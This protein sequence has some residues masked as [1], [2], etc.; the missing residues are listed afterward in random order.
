M[1][2]VFVRKRHLNMV[3]FKLVTQARWHNTTS[4]WGLNPVINVYGTKTR[5][6]TQNNSKFVFSFEIKCTSHYNE[7]IIGLYATE[8]SSFGEWRWHWEKSDLYIIDWKV[9]IYQL[10]AVLYYNTVTTFGTLDLFFILYS[11]GF[12]D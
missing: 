10:L 1:R 11:F 3:T 8:Q 12:S 5:L 9:H 2:L 7:C 4:S 6:E